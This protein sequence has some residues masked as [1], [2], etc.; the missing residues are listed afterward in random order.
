MAAQ[1]DA[2]SSGRNAGS[3]GP[4]SFS[5]TTTANDNR[6]IVV[7]VC[8]NKDSG[9][10]TG[11]TYNAVAL[12]RAVTVGSA[13]SVL[14]QLWYLKA[15]ATG[16]NTLSV[17]YNGTAYISVVATT[18]WNVDQTTPINAT[19]TATGS[20]TAPSVNLVTTFSAPTVF[21]SAATQYSSTADGSQ[22]QRGMLG[23]PFM[24]GGLSTENGT[25]TV[26]MSWSTGS[27]GAW[28]IVAMEANG[29]ADPTSIKTKN[30][31]AKAS[32]KTVNDLA[33]ASVKT[34]NDLS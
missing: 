24:W 20:S 16:A 23:E 10:I 29:L 14:S 3:S 26:T 25:G 12:T 17:A 7:A 32:V 18:Y 30:D 21:D 1:Y 22:T 27:S 15:P 34:I 2:T 5:H 6:L 4:V 19:A 33:I 9:D 28:S 8:A 31:L 13:G 11:V